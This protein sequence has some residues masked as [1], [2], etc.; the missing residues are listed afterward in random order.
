MRRET[1]NMRRR[2][3]LKLIGGTAGGILVAPMINIGRFRVFAGVEREYSARTI[4]LIGSSLVIDM[5]AFLTMN[6]PKMQGWFSDPDSYPEEEWEKVRTSGMDVLAVHTDA[7]FRFVANMNGFIANHD[8]LF[9]RIDS[10]EDLNRVKESGKIGLMIGTQQGELFQSI[11]DVNLFHGLGLRVSQL[12]GNHRTLLGDGCMERGDGGVS[13]F[14][15]AVIERMNEVGMAVDVSHA[16]DR[17]ALD[18]CDISRQPVLVS[19]SN[20]RALVP[21]HP[22]CFPDEVI[23]KMASTGGVMGITYLRNFVRDKE[24]TTIEHV[25]DHFDHVAKLVGVEHVGMGADQDLDGHDKLPPEMLK[26]MIANMDPRYAFRDRLN[27]DGLDHPKRTY[28]LTEALIRRGYNNTDIE[29]ILGGNFKRV[30]SE[31]WSA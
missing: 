20:C 16:G 21:G 3:A 9:M 22:R 13:K 15:A 10:V 26:R 31:I 7:G 24:P 12:T 30:L 25:V 4:D 23:Q 14:G 1:R 2:D 29:G 6:A 5:T 19:H 11:N 27:I 28:D 8:Q 17:T 18:A